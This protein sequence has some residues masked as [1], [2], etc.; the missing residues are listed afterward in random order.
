LKY[1]LWKDQGGICLFTGDA[2]PVTRL[3][4]Y[5]IEHIVPRNHPSGIIGPD[6]MIN[7]VLT[8]RETNTAKANRT[9]F[10]WFH[11][12]MPEQWDAYQKRV[13]SRVTALRNKKAQL[14]L[15]EDAPQLV[16]RYTAL[17]ETAWVSKLAQTIAS[18]YFG[19]K[20]GND[21]EGRKRVTVVSGGLT[22]RVRRKYRLNSLLNPCPASEDSF[23]WEETCEK[24]RSDDRHHALDAMVISFIP[25]WARDP[26]KE[27]FFRFPEGVHRELFAKEIASV[28]P[29]N[30]AIEKAVFEDKIY[31]RRLLEGHTFI[32]GRESLSGLAIKTVQNRETLRRRSDIETHRIVDGRIRRDVEAFWD[33]NPAATLEAWKEWCANY[34]RGINGPRVEK[35]LV[36][37]S[38]AEATDEYKNVSKD[39]DAGTRGQ[40]KR[41]AKHRGYFIYDR[42]APTRKEPNRMQVEVRPVFVFESKREVLEDLSKHT[43]W[44]NYGFFESGC[45]VRTQR[46]FEFQAKKYPADEFILGSVWA[47]RNAKLWHPI[48]QEVGPVGL[49]ILLDAGFK[50]I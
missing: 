7:Y 47:N 42:P 15:R 5:E 9:P 23:A 14:L 29:R 50:R 1:E 12:E 41:G 8:K 40:Y 39:V 17:A 22:A 36:T 45:Q 2:L 24:N 19:W 11:A 20:N 30:I 18:L 43:D 21:A 44:K 4:D 26:K 25:V 13:Q 10:E 16:D 38:K 31:G 49:R 3:S 48:H 35:V 46:E 32:V 33:G 37:K 6:A 27:G 28:K 34:R